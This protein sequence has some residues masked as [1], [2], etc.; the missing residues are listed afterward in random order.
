MEKIELLARVCGP[1][2]LNPCGF[3]LWGELRSVVHANN[4]HDLEA[5]KQNIREAIYNIQ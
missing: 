1:P 2:D 4:P 5:L 3:Y